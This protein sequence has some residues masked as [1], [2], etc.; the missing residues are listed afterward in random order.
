MHRTRRT[1]EKGT[2]DST[3][4]SIGTMG[5]LASEDKRERARLA[6]GKEEVGGP[7]SLANLVP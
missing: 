3:T 5:L 2:I 4:L 6:T 7:G 1:T